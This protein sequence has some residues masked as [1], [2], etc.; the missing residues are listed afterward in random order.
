MCHVQGCAEEALKD[1]D[2]ICEEDYS[3]RISFVF[4]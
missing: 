3:Q 2:W 4:W 1:F